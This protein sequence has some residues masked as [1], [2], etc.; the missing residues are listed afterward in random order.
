MLDR[1]TLHIKASVWRE[2]NKRRAERI[3]L[4]KIATLK[5]GRYPGPYGRYGYKEYREPGARGLT[6]DVDGNEEPIVRMIYDL[7]DSGLGTKAIRG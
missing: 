6:I 4:G 5:E 7:C 3:K 2:E 1:F